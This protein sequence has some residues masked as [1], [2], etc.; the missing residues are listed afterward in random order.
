MNMP[1]NEDDQ[2]NMK[3]VNEFIEDLNKLVSQEMENTIETLI[4]NNCA[5]ILTDEAGR[6]SYRLTKL[7]REMYEAET[8]LPA[9]TYDIY[10][11]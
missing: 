9:P 2:E 5:E 3:Y 6:F 4:K 11:K 1:N 7:G 8:G 10:L